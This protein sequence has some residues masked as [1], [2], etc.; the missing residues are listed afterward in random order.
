[1]M[2][3]M[4]APPPA[5]PEEPK[6][7]WYFGTG[8]LVFLALSIGPCMLPLVWLHPRMSRVKKAVFTTIIGAASVAL[9]AL[10]LYSY[11]LGMRYC[12]D[13]AFLE[14]ILGR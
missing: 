6:L 4:D 14:S 2:S 1:M 10:S 12:M 5:A 3:G 7:P 13:P 11:R 9:A 8:F